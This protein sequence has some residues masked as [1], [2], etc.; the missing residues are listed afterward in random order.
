MKSRPSTA[1]H[2]LPRTALIH[3][4]LQAY[5]LI[6]GAFRPLRRLLY[7]KPADWDQ[8]TYLQK[9]QWRCKHPDP[10][11]DYAKWVDKYRAKRALADEFN[12]PQNY[13]IVER[14][15]DINTE[16]LPHTYVMKATYG[17]D[18]NLL[19]KEGSIRGQNRDV[20]D[21]GKEA[22]RD[23]LYT[24]SSRWQKSIALDVLRIREI[25]YQYVTPG[26][27]F[28]EYIPVD[29]ELQM[30]LFDGIC[31][32]TLAVMREFDCTGPSAMRYRLYDE[33]W[34]LLDPG[35]HPNAGL[36]DRSALE[37]AAPEPD[38]LQRLERFC[39]G[40]DH[41]RADFLVSKGKMYFSEFTF[42]HNA[43]RPSL[44]GQYEDELGKFWH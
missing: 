29:Y 30:F 5:L 4:I 25:H 13:A 16:K 32:I 41:V 39:K 8:R 24:I 26:V 43:G 12:V 2:Y 23:N 38:F 6:T 44:L 42:T 11:V 19:V 1:T 10:A 28:E 37:I 33:H 14:P 35:S 9:M 21:Y 31:K 3:T 17:W 22:N 36:Y 20:S 7:K 40:F 27:L 18:M 34:V 15:S